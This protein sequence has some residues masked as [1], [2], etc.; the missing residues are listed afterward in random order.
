MDV[1]VLHAIQAAHESLLFISRG[2]SQRFFWLS[3]NYINSTQ[4]A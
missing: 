4:R 2:N 1:Y 3:V